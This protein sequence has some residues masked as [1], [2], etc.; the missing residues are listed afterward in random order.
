M[1]GS[2]TESIPDESLDVVPP[3][4]TA[5]EPLYSSYT[6]SSAKPIRE[7]E[8]DDEVKRRGGQGWMM[9]IDEA[10]RGPVLG[11]STSPRVD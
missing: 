4:V 8:Q 2:D 3:S 9:G 6:Y 7:G 5:G 11:A 10:G 1:A